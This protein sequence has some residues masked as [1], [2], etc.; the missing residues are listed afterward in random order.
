ESFRH[1]IKDDWVIDLL[2]VAYVGENGL[3]TEDQS[4]LHLVDVIGTDLCKDFQIFGD[5][6]ECCRIKGGS[7]T[8]I[9]KGLVPALERNSIEMHKGFALTR[10][11]HQN[12]QI[13]LSFDA[14]GGS[15]QRTFDAVILALPFTCLRNVEGLDSLGLSD[16]KLDC[17][18]NLGMGH[19]AK[20]MVGTRSR[21][22]RTPPASGL[23]V[24]SNG[25]ALSDLAFHEVWQTSDS[26][27][28][29]A[30]ILTNFLGGNAG[31]NDAKSAFADFRA[32]L[33]NMSPKMAESLDPDPAAVIP[34]F[35]SKHRFTLGSYSCAK[36]GQYTTMFDEAWKPALD[37]RLQFAG[38]HTSGA[39]YQ[40]YMNGAVRSG[41]RAACELLKLMALH[42]GVC[43]V[44]DL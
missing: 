43:P 8:L 15:K 10:I 39:K 17:I 33:A 21:V 37:G 28:G 11:D 20:I 23:P 25:S 4:S 40:G 22:W 5:S 29:K 30:G 32:G 44:D 41:N 1:K 26:Q 16:G 34:W 3:E 14:P 36:V 27:P 38:E 13:V 9:D 31:L 2:D 12:G 19:G 42:D 18:R 24:P 6:D 7:S 35:W